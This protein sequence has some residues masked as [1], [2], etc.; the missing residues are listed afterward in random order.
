MPRKKIGIICPPEHKHEQTQVCYT[1]H[2]C[3]CQWCVSEAR[4]RYQEKNGNGKWLAHELIAEIDHMVMLNQSIHVILKDLN[5]NPITAKTTFYKNGRGDLA[6]M[7]NRED[8][9]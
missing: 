8:S 3:R 6:R 1:H 7:L 4:H 9:R 5:V 2:G